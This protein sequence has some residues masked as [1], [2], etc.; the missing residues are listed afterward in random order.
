LNPKIVLWRRAE[1]SSGSG[2]ASAFRKRKIM[3]RICL[4][5]IG[6][7][8][9]IAMELGTPSRSKPSE[10]DPLEQLNL[11]ASASGDTLKKGDR[12]VVHRLPQE[13][14]V[15]PIAL[16]ETVSPPPPDLIA[17]LAEKNSDVV[18]STPKVKKDVAK[19][20]KPRPKDAA[21]GKPAAKLARAS[22]AAK[23]EKSKAV[24]ELKPCRPNA[25]DELLQALSLS[26]RCQT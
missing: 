23:A 22:K 13:A 1:H 7:G 2:Q 17:M 10:L 15:Q 12:L 25:F 9:L 5:V 11:G 20:P 26:S 4:I 21:P 14:P 24:V 3:M 18:G 16:A 19:K 8:V 6:L